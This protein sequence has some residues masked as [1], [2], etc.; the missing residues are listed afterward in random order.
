MQRCIATQRLEVRK[1][2]YET[3]ARHWL[4][5][6]HLH[7]PLID[8]G[9]STWRTASL[10]VGIAPQL[11]VLDGDRRLVVM[12]W[13]KELPLNGEA[14]RA[15]DWLVAHEMNQLAPGGIPAVLDLRR[16]RLHMPTRRPY[17]RS[18]DIQLEADADAFARLWRRLQAGGLTSGCP[19]AATTSS[20]RSGS[21][22]GPGR[23]S[24]RSVSTTSP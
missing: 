21:Q 3:L 4:N 6:K 11:S 1:Q 15:I 7:L 22:A 23:G 8:V 20:R 19:A 24:C 16:E 9:R 14:L 13:L 12:L 17:R 18:Y 5:L 2:H 10:D